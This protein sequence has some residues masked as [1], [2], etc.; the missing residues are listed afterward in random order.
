MM[1]HFILRTNRQQE[2]KWKEQFTVFT[3]SLVR[4]T[5]FTCVNKW[6][7]SLFDENVSE[8]GVLEII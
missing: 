5:V 6:N 4:P 8:I 1:E 2:K 3:V 7:Q